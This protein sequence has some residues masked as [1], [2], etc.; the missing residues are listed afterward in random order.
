M[1]SLASLVSVWGSPP[2]VRVILRFESRVC[3]LVDMIYK[4]PALARVCPVRDEMVD[5]HVDGS[6][7]RGPYR[8]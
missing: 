8:G 2:P 4:R 6:N 1:A 3:L 5:Q 7:L